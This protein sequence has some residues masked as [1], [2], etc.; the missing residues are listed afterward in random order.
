[1]KP[2]ILLED[3]DMIAELTVVHTPGH[4]DGSVSFYLPK[5]A[6]FTGDALRTSKKE[7]PE[8]VTSFTNANSSQAKESV[9]KLSTLEFDC[10]LPGHG[11]PIISNASKKL[12]ELVQ[13][14]F[15]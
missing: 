14:Q 5:E 8:L 10:L 9:R 15:P 7:I 12:K 3:S 4:T 11:P 13:K 1:M 6:L 2:D